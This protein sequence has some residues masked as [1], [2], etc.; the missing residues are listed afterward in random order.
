VRARHGGLKAML[1]A[2]LRFIFTRGHA[3]MW[4]MIIVVRDRNK[5]TSEQSLK[6]AIMRR[7]NEVLL[8]GTKYD[9]YCTVLYGTV[10]IRYQVYHFTPPSFF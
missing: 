10:G 2:V 3:K 5:Q 9:I 4:S 6:K 8:Y 7:L 1:P